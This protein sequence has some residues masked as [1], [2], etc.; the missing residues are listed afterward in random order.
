MALLKT[1]EDFKKTK[2]RISVEQPTK[3]KID[4][5]DSFIKIETNGIPSIIEIFYDG[6]ILVDQAQFN[7]YRLI[8]AEN[9]LSVFNPFYADI[10]NLTI[11]Y[12]GSLVVTKVIVTTSHGNKF[13]G[14][15]NN[16][17]EQDLINKQKTNP[18][19]D[20]LILHD[21]GDTLQKSIKKTPYRSGI[22]R[23]TINA[24]Y[25]NEKGKLQKVERPTA[26][27]TKSSMQDYTSPA[28]PGSPQQKAGVRVAKKPT[29]KIVPKRVAPKIAKKKG[30]Y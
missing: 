16:N 28:K 8:Y 11:S 18:E 9:K 21:E 30:S 3:S 22:A 4:V 24:N 29:R 13:I 23:P 15:I 7:F 26:A 14:S 6:E 20:T 1:L 27:S 10:K 2:D 12:S 19:D 17:I 5:L 25:F